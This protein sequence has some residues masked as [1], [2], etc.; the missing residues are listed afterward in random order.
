MS[1]IKEEK[2][3]Q[4]SKETKNTPSEKKDSISNSNSDEENIYQNPNQ[5]REKIRDFIIIKEIGQGSFGS[6]FLVE[7]ETNKKKYALKVINKDFLSRTERTEEALIERL[8][9]SRCKHPSIVR[10]SLSFQSKNKLFFVMEYCPN[11]D[12]DELLRKFG[13]FDPDL[14]LQIICELV[15]VIDYLHNEMNISHNDLKPSN[16]LLDA[17]FHI[18]LIDFS[19]AKIKGKIFDK[20]KGD[21]IPSEESISKDIIGTAEFISP[22]MVNQKITDYKTNDIWA[23]GIIIYMIFNGVSPFKDKNDFMTLDKV[24]EGKF[25]FIK[26]DIPDDV[27]DLINNILIEDTNKRLNIKQIKE[28]KYFKNNNINWDT[29][30][31]NKVPIDLE[32]LNQLNQLSIENNN[33]EN[34]WEQFCNDINNNNNICNSNSENNLVESENDFE[35]Q[36]SE[37][38]IKIVNNFFYPKEKVEKKINE[39]NGISGFMKNCGFIEKEVKMKMYNKEKRIDVFDLEKNKIIKKFELSDKT[40]IKTDKANELFIDGEKFKSSPNDVNNWINKINEVINS[41]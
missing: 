26:K 24:K 6:V 3:N 30:L 21:F 29:I 37:L 23:L 39:M 17:N 7:K 15:N 4:N 27:I 35:I 36:K 18:K 32:K 14:A 33:N 25:D 28:H 40:K 13:T 16:I 19:T 8:I 5:P 2:N 9:L 12:L 10:L 31:Q 34:F 38:P 22:E 11:K 20:H 1:T 41:S